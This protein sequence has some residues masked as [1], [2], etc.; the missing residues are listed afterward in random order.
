[1]YSIA[2]AQ[3]HNEHVAA[4]GALR[5]GMPCKRGVFGG[6]DRGMRPGTRT[7]V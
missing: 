4:K 5:A 7:N 6:R 1:M 3:S 2:K